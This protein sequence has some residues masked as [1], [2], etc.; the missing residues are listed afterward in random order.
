MRSL[1]FSIDLI[2]PAAL[3]PWCRVTL[4]QRWV[5]GI[6]LGVKGGW[7]VRLTTSPPSVSQLARK[8]GG[9][10][11]SQPYRP[12]RPVTGRDFLFF[13]LHIKVTKSLLIL[14]YLSFL[15]SFCELII[16]R[17]TQISVNLKYSLLLKELLK[18]EPA[19]KFVE[20]YHSVVSWK[21]NMED[22]TLNNFCKCS[23]KKCIMYFSVNVTNKFCRHSNKLVSSYV[24]YSFSLMLK[25]YK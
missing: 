15:F 14:Q 8:C 20:R 23:N 9:F 19:S 2:F 13:I 21:L 18:F 10:N 3:W 22:L 5:P 4:Y 24:W 25:T 12:A 17:A 16:F 6:V 11:V 7:R 1:D